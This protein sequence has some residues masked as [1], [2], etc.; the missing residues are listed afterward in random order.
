MG[1]ELIQTFLAIACIMGASI[2]CTIAASA[3]NSGRQHAHTP[4]DA[5]GQKAA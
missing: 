1:A 2:G 3:R 4:P 5:S